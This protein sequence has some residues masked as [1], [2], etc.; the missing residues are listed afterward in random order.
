MILKT[1]N[2]LLQLPKR[3]SALKNELYKSFDALGQ[4]AVGSVGPPDVAGA[5]SVFSCITE[6][7]RASDVLMHLPAR[8]A[9]L[10]TYKLV[11]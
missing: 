11:S 6:N 7:L 3:L 9:L 10:C 2:E 5:N 8:P 4:P 1:A